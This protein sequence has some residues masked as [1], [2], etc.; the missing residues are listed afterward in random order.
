M[1]TQSQASPPL[2]VNAL[3]FV[4]ILG[5]VFVALH[6]VARRKG[7]T[8][9]S[10]LVSGR[11]LR[12]LLLVVGAVLGYIGSYFGQAGV[13]R[14]FASL[15]DYLANARDIL[16]PPQSAS[17]LGVHLTQSVCLTAWIGLI[18]GVAAMGGLIFYVDTTNKRPLQ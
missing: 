10:L 15:G 3:P 1:E 5:V 7:T 11:S 17:A 14:A 6:F 13:L 4:V 12:Y 18:L 8:L 16:I 2:W 9:S